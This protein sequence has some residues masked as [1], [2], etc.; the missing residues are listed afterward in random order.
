MWSKVRIF[1]PLFGRFC[2]LFRQS[3]YSRP[4]PLRTGYWMVLRWSGLTRGTSWYNFWF[5]QGETTKNIKMTN[6][7]CTN[8]DQNGVQ[9]PSV[10]STF[11][12]ILGNFRQS[13]H[14]F[15]VLITFRSITYGT[16]EFRWCFFGDFSGFGWVS[17]LLDGSDADLKPVLKYSPMVFAIFTV[18]ISRFLA[19]IHDFEHFS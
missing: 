17:M 4:Q 6:P 16:L 13:F 18:Q 5:V 11:V 3:W 1:C 19:E 15:H 12:I 7:K 8:L 2:P 14:V 10:L 9:G